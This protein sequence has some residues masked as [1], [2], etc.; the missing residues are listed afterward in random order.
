LY[1]LY[2][3][4]EQGLPVTLNARVIQLH[5]KIV[6]E[7]VHHHTGEPIAITIG[8]PVKGLRE[9][10]LTQGQGRGKSRVE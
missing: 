2:K 1:E 5:N 6:P 7:A 9:D 4:V 8:Q 3:G 10:P